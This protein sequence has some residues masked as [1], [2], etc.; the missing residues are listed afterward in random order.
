[1]IPCS[2]LNRAEAGVAGGHPQIAG[3]GQLGPS[4]QRGPFDC[5]DQRE[6]RREHG[7]E[8]PAESGSLLSTFW[9]N[10]TQSATRQLAAGSGPKEL[11]GRLPGFV[12]DW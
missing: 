3:D 9:K 10:K 11:A 2:A 1:M 6:R 4:A 12:Y 5:C 7:V 8:Q